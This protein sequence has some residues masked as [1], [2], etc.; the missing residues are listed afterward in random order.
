MFHGSLSISVIE[1]HDR[2]A[3][4]LRGRYICRPASATASARTR[5]RR[6]RLSRRCGGCLAL[7]KVESCRSDDPGRSN[8]KVS[9]FHKAAPNL[10]ETCGQ[11]RRP[12]RS[13][14][15]GLGPVQRDQINGDV[16]YQEFACGTCRQV[17][18]NASVNLM[19]AMAATATPNSPVRLIGSSLP[20]RA[21]LF[22]A[23][24][25]C[26]RSDLSEINVGHGRDPR[27]GDGRSAEPQLSFACGM[28][29]A[30]FRRNAEE[31]TA[32]EPNASTAT[33]PDCFH[34]PGGMRERR[35]ENSD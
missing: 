32:N 26:K 21:G 11:F 4:E 22:L 19:M 15:E 9:A 14:Q 35:A 23:R 31:G 12:R 27:G 34:R 6:R 5:A 29:V 2:D 30:T 18:E 17:G 24:S 8:E 10:R 16:L 28:D 3:R 13:W 33:F 1:G 25:P 20:H 7:R